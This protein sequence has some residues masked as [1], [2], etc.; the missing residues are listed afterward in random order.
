VWL[1]RQNHTDRESEA[2]MRKITHFLAAVVLCVISALGQQ[3]RAAPQEAAAQTP[4][5]ALMEM[6][7]NKTPGTF[8]KH[9]PAATRAAMEKSGALTMLQQYSH[10]A[11]QVSTEGNKVQTFET[12]EVMVSGQNPKTGQKYE[13]TVIKDVARGDEDDIELSF[14]TY[15]DGQP[16]RSPFMPQMVFMMKKEA[17]IWT[18]NELSF[19]IHVPLADP[20]FLKAITEKM[21]QP[22]AVTRTSFTPQGETSVSLAGGDPMVI[23]A[24]RSILKAENTYA[25]TY[26]TVGFTCTLSNLDGF[27]GGE[28]NEHQAML[29]NSSLAAGKRYGFVFKLSECSGDPATAFRLAAVPNENVYGRKAFCA[30]QSG[31]IRSSD[32]GNPNSCF[33][34]GTPIP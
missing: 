20:D 33:T 8:I 26:S 11:S 30:D 34:S 17:Q 12:G 9:L 27:G 28:P 15:K 18:L 1:F 19:T 29:I 14:R 22:Q 16:Q 7:F 25:A 10:M 6:F 23:A 24:M 32:D 4:R 13:V 21:Q 3:S 31:V 2:I 5:Q